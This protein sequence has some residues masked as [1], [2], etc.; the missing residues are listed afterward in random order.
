[1]AASLPPGVPLSQIPAG[2]PPPGVEPLNLV[3]PP[4][5]E[6]AII[7]IS[8]IMIALASFFVIGRVYLNNTNKGRKLGWDDGMN[9]VPFGPIFF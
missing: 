4:T 3:N 7:V 5:K 8:A 9:S 2:R 1:M 6:N